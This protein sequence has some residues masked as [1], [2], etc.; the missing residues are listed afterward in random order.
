MEYNKFNQPVGDIVH[1][2]AP[3]RPN[4]DNIVGELITLQP[5]NQSHLPDLYAVMCHPD[6]E[7]NWTYLGYGP[8][9]NYES[10][11]NFYGGFI[12]GPD[13]FFYAVFDH[14]TQKPLGVASYL[15][16]EPA[17]GVIEI[18]H[19]FWSYKMQRTPQSAGAVHLMINHAKKLGYR[20]IEW[21]CN[22][23][24][25]ASNRAALKYGF[26]FEGTFRQMFVQKGRNRDSNWYSIIC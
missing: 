8:F 24:N 14:A 19:I 16:I 17:H 4:G 7:Q 13:P 2:T 18:G 26:E 25:L 6:Y 21:K 20:R 1:F 9:N 22:S 23:L 3:P 5:L 15:R 12:G 10:F 11:A